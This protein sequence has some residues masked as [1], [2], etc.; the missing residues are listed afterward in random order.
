MEFSADGATLWFTAEDKGV[1]PIFKMKADGTGLTPVYTEG[2]ST[3]LSAKSGRI[4]FL[5][6]NF[7]RPNELF[8]LDPKSG[9]VRQL[10]H[11]NQTLVDQLDLG[12][13]EPYWFD[14]AAGDKVQGWLILPPGLRCGEDLP[15]GATDARRPEHHGAR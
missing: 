2:T 5:N 4:V 7:N 6:D 8:T 10:T 14:G 15:D 1:M 13:V 12:K 9:A 11:F 3:E